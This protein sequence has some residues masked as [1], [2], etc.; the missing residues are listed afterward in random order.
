MILPAAL[1]PLTYSFGISEF[2]LFKM[3]RFGI[4][5]LALLLL[6]CQARTTEDQPGT[7]SATGEAVQLPNPDP[8]D[9][10]LKLPNGFRAYIFADNLG[11]A[12]HLAV[13]SNGDVYVALRERKDGGGIVALRDT[14]GDGR[15]DQIERFGEHSGTGLALTR[16]HL[17]FSS[18]L[19]IYRYPLSDGQLV[20]QG[21]PQTV[22]SGF[23]QQDGHASKAFTLDGQG[24]LYV[25]VGAPSNA[26]M[27]QKRTKGSP[28]QDPC[29]ELEWQASIWRFSA[30][31]TGQTQQEHGKQ[32][33]RGIRNVVAIDWNQEDQN[34]YV[35]QHGRDQL[36]EFWPEKFTPEHTTKLPAE[37]F[38]RVRE[39]DNFGWP[40]CYFD[41]HQNKRILGPEYGGDGEQVGRCD[42]YNKPIVAFPAHWAP[43]DLLFY[44]G[45]Q[46]PER[47]RNGAFVVFHGSWNRPVGGQ[48]GYKVVFVPFNGSD[49]AGDYEVFANGFAGQEN[50]EAPGQADYRPMGIAQGPDGT[51]YISDSK[52][53]RIWRIMYDGQGQAAR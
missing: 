2:L 21:E 34:L 40:Y 42:Q 32:F 43:N 12:R 20:P 18:N 23:P 17:Y 49:P 8:D 28:G 31:Q 39:G 37:E 47:Y 5:V 14:D 4:P 52:K 36:S 6:G 16:D 7:L 13:G 30:D 11:Q 35:V 24:N 9:G 15:A 38:L 46:L 50:L 3:G 53:G 33:A 1:S 22:V 10:G 41:P 27:V 19:A 29:P 48:E 25:N 45:Q 44:T 51:L 26:C